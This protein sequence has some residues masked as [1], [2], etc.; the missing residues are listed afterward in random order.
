MRV[1]NVITV[2]GYVQVDPV[3]TGAVQLE[4]SV[5]VS[6][7]FTNFSQASGFARTDNGDIA[8]IVQANAISDGLSLIMTATT[9]NNRNVAFQATYRIP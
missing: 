8:G 3:N 7:D 2:S 1:G 4:V 6:V 9:A 5:P